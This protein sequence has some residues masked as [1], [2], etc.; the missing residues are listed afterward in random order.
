MDRTIDAQALER[1]KA[2]YLAMRARDRALRFRPYETD[3]NQQ[4]K[5]VRDYEI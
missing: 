3:E 2:D 4:F 5:T 1:I